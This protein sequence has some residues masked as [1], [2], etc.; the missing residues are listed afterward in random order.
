LAG[1]EMSAKNAGFTLIE[2]IVVI[3]IL[4][5]LAAVAVPKFVDLGADARAARVNAARAA[6]SGA[7]SLAHSIWLARGLGPND[8]VVMEGQSIE[9]KNGY[10]SYNGIIV[11]SGIN[12]GPSSGVGY[13]KSPAAGY[14]VTDGD[15]IFLY[16]RHSKMVYSDREN[17]FRKQANGEPQT[18]MVRYAEAYYPQAT[19]SALIPPLIS[20][21]VNADDCK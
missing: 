14:M 15:Y 5:I 2:L 9:M 7:S 20:R 18:C 16:D 8:P 19:A 1:I 17:Y 10:P 12:V 3:V 6:I 21:V 13:S 4:G 11:A